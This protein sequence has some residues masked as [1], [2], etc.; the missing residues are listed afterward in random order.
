MPARRQRAGLGLAVAH[1]A[2][3]QQIRVVE[4]GAVGVQQRVTELTAFVDR[5]RRLGRH[6]AGDSAG[7]RELAKQSPQSL[8]VATDV[9]IDLA[10]GPV[11]VGAGHEAR[12]AVTGSGDVDHVQIARLDRAVHVRVDEVQPGRRAPVP[13]QARLDVLGRERL[14]QQRVVE[15]VDLADRQVVRGPPPLIDQGELVGR[16]GVARIR[17]L[18]S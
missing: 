12:A 18:S 4:H 13:E 6:V 8:G 5:A 3:R 9:R 11:E 7:E 16:E 15:Q 2:Q 10:V 14:A 17:S 1:H